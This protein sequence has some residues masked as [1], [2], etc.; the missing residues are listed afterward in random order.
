MKKSF[1]GLVVTV[2]LT[3]ISAANSS[4]DLA[5]ELDT[6]IVTA[7]RMA[8]HNY[9]IA[10]NVTVI[11]KEAIE[12]SNAQTVP[13][14]LRE[15]LGVSVY[16]Y[17]TTKSANI[18]IRGFGETAPS[19][20]L[21]LINDRKINAIDL[22]GP[23]LLRIPIGSV[24]R[25]EIIRGAGSVLYGDN[26][27]GGVVN[28]IT[29]KG[30]GDL[31]GK[32]G[33]TYGSY[34][35]RSENLEISGGYKDALS[36]YVYSEYRD[37]G[38]YRSNSNLLSKDFNTRLGYQYSDKLSVDLIGGWH[39]DDYGL[40]GGLT[41]AQLESLGRR[42]SANE[43][44]FASTK[45]RNIQLVFDVKP[46]PYDLYLGHFVIDASYSNKDGYDSFNSFGPFNTKR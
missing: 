11:T 16:N 35:S 18:D 13:D 1:M 20:I 8:Q 26:A 7:T 46:W 10:G 12:A 38:G 23:D 14:I 27:V 22:S 24:E 29:K 37:D 17:G 36:Y 44:D 45:D 4:A 40:P 39:E 25:I 33:T 28:I 30:K 5:K 42:G 2:I 3:V 43:Q 6:V 9:K 21:V 19:N 34:D 15:S 41:D 32:I 31:S